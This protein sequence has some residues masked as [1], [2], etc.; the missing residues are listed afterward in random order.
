MGISDWKVGNN[1]LRTFNISFEKVWY[2]VTI[3]SPPPSRPSCEI[4]MAKE[5]WVFP[6]FR[7]VLHRI[8]APS[9]LDNPSIHFDEKQT[10]CDETASNIH[11]TIILCHP[12]IS[13]L[14]LVFSVANA[15]RSRTGAAHNELLYRVSI[16]ISFPC[17]SPRLLIPFG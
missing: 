10:H 14:K 13:N 6:D 12:S 1:F 16:P 7:S 9:L 4:E 5:P 17:S 11:P 3:P 2:T 8:L 15:P